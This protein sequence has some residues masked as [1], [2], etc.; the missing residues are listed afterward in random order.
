MFRKVNIPVLGIVE[1][2]SL[3][4]CSNCG[5][6]EAIFGSDGGAQLAQQYTALCL[7]NCLCNWI[8]ALKPTPAARP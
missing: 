5:H 8:F 1:N 4:I 6:Q 3:H 7:G 2:M